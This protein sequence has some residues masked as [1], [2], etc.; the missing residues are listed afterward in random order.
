MDTRDT[1]SGSLE[2]GAFSSQVNTGVPVEIVEAEHQT[3]ESVL[4]TEN[5]RQNV[6]T[7]SMDI[8]VDSGANLDS[9]RLS[10]VS[11]SMGVGSELPGI[12]RTSGGVNMDVGNGLVSSSGIGVDASQLSVTVEASSGGLATSTQ[13]STSSIGVDTAQISGNMGVSDTLAAQVQEVDDSIEQLRRVSQEAIDH[14]RLGSGPS[15]EINADSIRFPPVQTSIPENLHMVQPHHSTPGGATSTSRRSR[16]VLGNISYGDLDI[17][18]A[19]DSGVDPSLTVNSSMGG[20]A[21]AMD[22]TTVLNEPQSPSSP[23]S[24]FDSSEFLNTSVLQQDEVTQRLAQSGP[25]GVA[26]AAAIMTSRKRKRSHTFES[27]P[28]LR[29]RHCSKL[30][31]KLKETIEELAT[32]VGLQAV[33]VTYRPGKQD[34]REE[35]SFKVFGAAPLNNAV[36]NQK[37]SIIAEMDAALHQQAPPPRNQESSLHELPSLVFDGIPTPVHKMTQAQLRAFIPTMLKF[38]TGRGKPGWGKEDMK[39][40]WWPEEAPWSNVRSDSRTEAQKKQLSWTDALR[41]IVISCYIHHCRLDLLPEF[42]IEHLQ[43]TLSPEVAGQLQVQLERLQQQQTT[44][45]SSGSAVALAAE[46]ASSQPQ[47]LIGSENQQVFTV[48]TGMG[49][50]DTSGMPTLADA[51]LAE[52]AAKLQQV[53][54]K[55]IPLVLY[56]ICCV[57][58]FLLV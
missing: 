25:I 26:A 32:R 56:H 41:R 5:D 13:L 57:T 50:C 44:P 38:S 42:S 15:L 20:S 47:E 29:K 31:R 43:N 24:N 33:V 40:P 17:S 49:N 11:N 35:P 34:P 37:D 53:G 30:V 52:A 2:I 9:S 51:S 22:S 58:T 1:L 23:E 8:S 4:S 55:F 7:E 46:V 10:T 27:N 48:D 54:R 36:R 16:Q 6:S 21:S 3:V 45:Q 39:P 12:P 19:I 14:L 18:G 28:A